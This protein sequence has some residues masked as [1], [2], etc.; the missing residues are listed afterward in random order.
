MA[1]NNHISLKEIEEALSQQHDPWQAGVTSMSALMPDEQRQ[2]L[3]VK[4][5]PGELT[6]EQVEQQALQQRDQI[7]ASALAR[8]IKA[9]AAYDL[10]NVDGANFIT[11]ITDQLDCGSCVA[12]GTVAA[13]EGRLRKQRNDPALDVNLSEAHLFFVHARARGYNC[14]TGWWPAEAFEDFKTKGVVDEACYPYDLSKRDGS[15][16]CSDAAQRLTRISGFTTLTGKPADIKEWLVSR[17][18]VSACFNVYADFFSYR[19]GIYKHVAGELRG[20]HCVSIIGYNDNPGY[21]ICKNSWG[22]SWGDQGFFNIAYGECAIESWQ[23]HGADEIVNTGWQNNSRVLGLWSID[24]DRNAWAYFQALGWRKIST[25]TDAVFYQL[26][27]DLISAKA[28]ARPV[29]FYEEN[30]VIKQVYVF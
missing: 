8:G 7:R 1:T 12:F 18:P 4:P 9:P 25:E 17:G 21:W 14:D 20:G 15:G 3:G 27:T 28:A 26:L 6:S 23:N 24:Q 5:P 30:S 10:R 2:R 29:N 16:L 19:S 13:V 22:K 11:P